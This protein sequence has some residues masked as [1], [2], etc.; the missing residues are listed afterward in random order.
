MLKTLKDE[1]SCYGN[2]R[3]SDQDNLK[4]IKQVGISVFGSL[5]R[6]LLDSA[7]VMNITSVE[8]C[9]KPHI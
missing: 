2:K 8:L 3:C 5:T 9:H 4:R 6:I 7:T 1:R